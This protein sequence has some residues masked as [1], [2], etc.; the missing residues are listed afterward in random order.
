LFFLVVVYSYSCFAFEI[1]SAVSGKP[2]HELLTKRSISIANLPEITDKKQTAILRGAYWN[3]DPSRLIWKPDDEK[4]SIGG[5]WFQ[6]FRNARE[7]I[8]YGRYYILTDIHDPLTLTAR[9]HF[10]DLQF[11]HSMAHRDNE[12][13]KHT[14]MKIMRWARFTYEVALG[15]IP[16]NMQLSNIDSLLS[17]FTGISTVSDLFNNNNTDIPDVA[18][19]SLLH[20]IQDSYAAGH[21]ER[22]SGSE[23]GFS[24]GLI[25]SFH[26]YR[27]QIVSCHSAD[28]DLPV[29]LEEDCQ[30]TGK[31]PITIGA[32]IIK[33]AY[34]KKSWLEVE[35]FL[36][37]TVFPLENPEKDSS[38][39]PEYKSG[40]S[41][42]RSTN[43]TCATKL[44]I[45]CDSPSTPPIQ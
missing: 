21:V 43:K 38:P 37:Y 4:P 10:G 40:C 13:A 44:R 22:K 19:G 14:L 17:Q 30:L 9:S 5:T 28:D 11:L 15:H 35:R 27:N 23:P 33:F 12:A 39:G 20:L 6:Y 8:G 42:N 3:D 2:V 26:S 1:S 25:V 34:E 24:K 32:K 29:D 45:N 16:P 18:L 41:S 31:D 7:S 36:L